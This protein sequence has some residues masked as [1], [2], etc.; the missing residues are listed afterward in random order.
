LWDSVK[1]QQ[2]ARHG[3]AHRSSQPCG[4]HK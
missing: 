2:K 3:T 4:S 1:Q